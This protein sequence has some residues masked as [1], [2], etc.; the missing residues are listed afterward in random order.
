MPRSVD[1]SL[2]YEAL[3]AEYG[4]VVQVTEGSAELI[5]QKLY[6]LRKEN[7]DEDLMQ[8]SI[9]WTPA[10]PEELWIVKQRTGTNEA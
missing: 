4:I 10:N 2:W 3:A 7:G 9:V 6:A 1:I 5:R 8:L